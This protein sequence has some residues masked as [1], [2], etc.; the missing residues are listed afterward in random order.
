M[1]ILG[2]GLWASS[3]P[4]PL[5]AHYGLYKRGRDPPTNPSRHLRKESSLLHLEWLL[6]EGRGR[7]P[8]AAAAAAR[9]RAAA[10][11]A[12]TTTATPCPGHA[13]S[14]TA[15]PAAAA[16]LAPPPPPSSRR[17]RPCSAAAA[18]VQHRLHLHLHLQLHLRQAPGKPL[19]QSLLPLLRCLHSPPRATPFPANPDFPES[20]R[21]P[22]HDHPL[23]P[24]FP[25]LHPS[26]R[27]NL[28]PPYSTE[29]GRPDNPLTPILQPRLKPLSSNPAIPF[30]S[31][32][33]ERLRAL[34]PPR[35][36][37]PCH[38]PPIR[39]P[40]NPPTHRIR[41]PLSPRLAPPQ[42]PPARKP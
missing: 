20:S 12:A 13:D 9:L 24:R 6:T 14:P 38:L 39:R 2:F 23:L 1:S 16:D 18:V 15:A 27:E 37:P 4:F 5:S 41:R 17:R 22:P 10:S 26:S 42:I 7:S 11:A 30:A 19:L 29:L 28:P 25:L 32:H 34:L 40:A 31:R 33:L 35:G 21:S 36:P 8:T 3:G